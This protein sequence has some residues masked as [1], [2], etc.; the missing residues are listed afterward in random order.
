MEAPAGKHG[1]GIVFEL[2]TLW[3]GELLDRGGTVEFRRD[4]SRRGAALRQANHGRCG[5]L[6]RNNIQRRGQ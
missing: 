4:E 2:S 6:V 3:R 5:K 1:C